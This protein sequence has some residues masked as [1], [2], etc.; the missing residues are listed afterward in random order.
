MPSTP[1]S[2][3]ALGLLLQL[4]DSS[5]PTGAFSHSFG[6]ESNISAGTVHDEDTL[7][8]WLSVYLDTQLLRTD[9]LAMR[10]AITRELPVEELDGWLDAAV[11]PV[12]VRSASRKM[13]TQL[14]RLAPH[15]LPAD[16]FEAIQVMPRNFCLVFAVL[17]GAA[18]AP[19][20]QV[21]H[22]YLMGAVTSLVQNAVRAVPL[23]QLAGARVLTRLR[24][25]VARAAAEALELS[26]DEFGAAAPGLEISQMRHEH[27]RA[28][29]FMS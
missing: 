10:L 27:L 20:Q 8:A 23:G 9:A 19:L 14:G 6:L 17:A 16:A 3:D 28:R 24:D 5:L 7:T 21:L 4:G 13:G 15:L 29:M 25:P 1:I 12:Q 11:V 26:P 2:P 22:T 18:G